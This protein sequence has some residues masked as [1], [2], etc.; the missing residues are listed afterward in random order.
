MDSSGPGRAK[1]ELASDK[2]VEH[3]AVANIHE[4]F[5][6]ITVERVFAPEL[7]ATYQ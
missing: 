4:R 7:L 1:D 5:Y 6:A 2:L 3:Q